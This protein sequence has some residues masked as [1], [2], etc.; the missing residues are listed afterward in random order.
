[1]FDQSFIVT[2]EVLPVRL[3]I[4]NVIFVMGDVDATS[5]VVRS[6]NL[7]GNNTHKLKQ[8]QNKQAIAREARYVSYSTASPTL[9]KTHDTD[10]RDVE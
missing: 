10:R 6:R 3:P 1:M 2:N 9:R 5:P 4:E 7:T 8:P